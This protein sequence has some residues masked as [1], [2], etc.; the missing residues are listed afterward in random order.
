MF[1]PRDIRDTEFDRIVRG[2]NPEDVDGFLSQLADQMETLIAEKEAAEKKVL[3]MSEKMDTYRE[4]GDALR[5]VLLTAEKMKTQML[6]EAQEQ[7]DKMLTEARESSEKM[8]SEAQAQSD[9][10][11]GAIASKVAIEEANLK[12]L[13]KQVSDFK[14]SVLGL[15]K[16][17]L[18]QL[19]ELPEDD[20]EPEPEM[21]VNNGMEEIAE[22]PD[23]PQITPIEEPTL[24]APKADDF[25][26]P[27][28]D[29]P[30]AK[31]EEVV[32][33]EVE[34][35]A[36]AVNNSFDAFSEPAESADKGNKFGKLDFGDSFTFG[37]E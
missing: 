33:K 15:Y 3:S 8:V 19:S 18:E 4:D 16:S 13:K 37:A 24:E 32:L 12:N 26:F 23:M 27:E 25:S 29:A 34:T 5:S 7:S 22:L 17:H 1:T 31:T 28:F 35:A 2:Y 36:P 21:P 11:V 20:S 30:A 6:T 10:I 9:S 14:N